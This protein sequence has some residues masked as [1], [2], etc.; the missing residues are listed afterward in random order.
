MSKRTIEQVSDV[1]NFKSKRMKLIAKFALKCK[2][3][4]N[5]IKK[6]KAISD[7]RSMVYRRY[8][9]LY[10]KEK[11]KDV[12]VLSESEKIAHKWVIKDLESALFKHKGE[13]E[14]LKR[15]YW[16]LRNERVELPPDHVKKSTECDI[17]YE[18]CTFVLN[19]CYNACSMYLCGKC[20]NDCYNKYEGKCPQC[21]I[22]MCY[23]K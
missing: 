18:K 22:K 20:L 2:N 1:E 23:L 4:K 12:S 5:E 10:E 19:L 6:I 13:F 16:E 14:V 17:C 8:F 21:K 11:A 7:A 9:V 15:K 3:S